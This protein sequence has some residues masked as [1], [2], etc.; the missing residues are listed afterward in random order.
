MSLTSMDIAWTAGFLEGEGSFS[1]AIWKQK[2]YQTVIAATQVQ[3]EPL[4]RLVAMFGGALNYFPRPKTGR[5]GYIRQPIWRWSLSGVRARGL[6][7]TLYQMMSPRRRE[8]ISH[9]IAIWKT[10]RV[11]AQYRHACVNGHLFST[12]GA[13]KPGYTTERTRRRRCLTCHKEST[14]RYRAEKK[15]NAS[16]R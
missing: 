5:E 6:M 8:Q 11:A 9:A 14:R 16:A 1:M 15:A 12:H 3:K 2:T 13:T 10:R 7:F 4:E